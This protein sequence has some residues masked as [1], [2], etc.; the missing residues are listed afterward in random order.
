[1]DEIKLCHLDIRNKLS[2]PHLEKAILNTFEALMIKHFPSLIAFLQRVKLS[3]L[4]RIQLKRI[5]PDTSY[6]F[7]LPH[8][9]GG[10]G[11]EFVLLNLLEAMERKQITDTA[12]RFLKEVS[13]KFETC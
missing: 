7:I 11:N 12:I 13:H 3:I 9:N 1:M 8:L 6:E 4:E 2:Q 5:V 10:L